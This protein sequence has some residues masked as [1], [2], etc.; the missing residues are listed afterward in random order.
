MKH[1]ELQI[2]ELRSILN[3]HF[4]WNKA[5]MACFVGMLISLMIVKT[6]N[7]T[8]LALFFPSQASIPS[9]YR[10]I[11]RFFSG[12]KMNYNEVA[13]FIMKLFGFTENDYYLSMDRTNWKLGKANINLLVLAVVYKGAAIPI[14]WLPLNKQGNSNWKERIALMKRFIDQF[15]K[16]H[17]KGLLADREF[18]GG[19]WI[20]WLIQEEI[21]FNIRIKKNLYTVNSRGEKIHV[22]RLFSMLK[23][24]ESLSLLD[25]RLLGKYPV[26]ISAL[27]LKDGKLLILIT[28][29]FTK[30][31]VEEYGLR[32]EIETLF[33]CL[34]GRGFNLEDTRVVAYLRIKKLLVLPV[35]AFCWAHKVGEWKHDSILPIKVKTHQRRSQSIFRYGLDHL[36]SELFTPSIPSK[37]WMQQLISF[38]RPNNTHNT[39][40]NQ[41]IMS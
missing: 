32:W 23:I 18:I 20:K 2:N 13:H 14:Y 27:R 41:S 15:G 1:S 37:K 12:H 26:F 7:L 5:R 38:L 19:K 17:I 24:G 31:A 36:Q 35:I 16:G 4:N 33:G 8:Q 28:P 10:R 21:P 9:R 3:E 22:N 25:A 29:K 6:V 40:Y 39:V 34:K 11:Q 30:N